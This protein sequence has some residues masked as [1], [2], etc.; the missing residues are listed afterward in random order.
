MKNLCK[1][2]SIAHLEG[3]YYTPR[4]DKEILKRY[5]E[6]LICLSGPFYS[7]LGI[8]VRSGSEEEIEEEV[9]FYQ[10]LFGDDFYL[11]VGLNRMTHGELHDCGVSAEA[12]VM[13]KM[14]SSYTAQEEVLAAFQKISK[15]KK[16]SLV[17]APDIRYAEKDDYFAH[18]V[19]MNVAS[20]ETVQIVEQASLWAASQMYIKTRKRKIA[21]S[22]NLT[23]YVF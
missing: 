19:M 5:H 9:S 23:F 6:G 12:H 4:I 7:P 22:Y 16:I 11:Q 18:E 13:Q 10:N 1:I 2:S 14:E 21:S 8:A 20:G 3:F 17:V 15:E